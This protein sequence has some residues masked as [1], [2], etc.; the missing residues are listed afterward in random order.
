MF[1]DSVSN[2]PIER[3]ILLR[4]WLSGLW[5]I[6]PIYGSCE[7]TTMTWLAILS[8]FSG[9][10]RTT[11]MV[12]CIFAQYVIHAHVPQKS[13]AILGIQIG[14]A[15]I[16]PHVWYTSEA[17]ICW[18]SNDAMPY[19]GCGLSSV[20]DMPPSNASDVSVSEVV[21]LGSPGGRG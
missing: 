3:W 5:S 17:T 19:F 2:Q 14:L 1:P 9:L 21:L 8:P 6:Y 18:R 16:F 20:Q 13:L 15:T 4:E 11:A 10:Y 7:L 12:M